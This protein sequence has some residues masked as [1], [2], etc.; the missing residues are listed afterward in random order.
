M[1]KSRGIRPEIK[2]QKSKKN[3]QSYSVQGN[4]LVMDIEKRFEHR[5]LSFRKV[6]T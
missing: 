4:A 5:M 3:T 1:I 2:P 6:R